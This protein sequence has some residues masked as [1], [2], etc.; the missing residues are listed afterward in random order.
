MIPF[1]TLKEFSLCA[2][3]NETYAQ[4]VEHF[5]PLDV[6]LLDH[7]KH[8]SHFFNH[9]GLLNL[10]DLTLLSTWGSAIVGEVEIKNHCQIILPYFHHQHDYRIDNHRVSFSRSCLFIPSS[11][12][13]VHLNSSVC[14]ATVISIPQDSLLIAAQAIGGPSWDSLATQIALEQPSLLCQLHDPRRE[15]L[16][17]LL[18]EALTF[19]DHALKLTATVN[20]MLRLD[21]LIRRLI[22]ML[23]HP[24]LFESDQANNEEMEPFQHNDLVEWMWAHI[25]DPISLSQLEQRSNYSRRSLQQA[26]K[27]HF[28]C[29]PM[30]WLRQQ[31][32]A[33]AHALLAH[34]Q[35]GSITAI[36]HACGYLSVASFSRDFHTRYGVRPSMLW[37]R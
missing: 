13:R 36:A 1:L 21:D 2:T 35:G 3:N 29:G 14:A 5:L 4:A 18:V 25:K 27:K 6:R 19:A 20:P 30:Q 31:R 16:H 15:R 12:S 9:A 33:K 34:H 28:G 24:D 10:G 11:A 32:L 22:V 8:P 17:S 7:P 26:F 23:L 37:R